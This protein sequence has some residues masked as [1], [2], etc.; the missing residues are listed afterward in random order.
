MI[1]KNHPCFQGNFGKVSRIALTACRA[2]FAAAAGG[3]LRADAMLME[4]LEAAESIG[5][6]PE[7][8]LCLRVAGMN[9][10]MKDDGALAVANFSAAYEL[11][12]KLGD[13]AGLAET[14]LHAAHPILT[15]AGDSATS[16]AM[17]EECLLYFR[18]IGDTSSM[19]D[20]LDSTAIIQFM[21]G[22]VD[23]ADVLYRE[24]LA[25]ARE[26][27]HRLVVARAIGGLALVA[28]ERGQAEHVR[29]I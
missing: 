29:S 26:A 21:L 13:R 16:Q 15:W 28:A 8:A 7:Q 4:A 5:S 11:Y 17:I 20:A 10:Q 12:Q 24:S 3:T 25:L 19:A 27:G 1:D 9:A 22:E 18:E 2:Q 23:R 14:A 6:L